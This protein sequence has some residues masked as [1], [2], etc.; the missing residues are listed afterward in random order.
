M[1]S[2]A[3]K[4]HEEAMHV[5]EGKSGLWGFLAG[6]IVAAFIAVPLSGAFAFATHPNTQQLFSGR[7]DETS[8][9]GYTAFWWIV[10]IF[11]LAL[12][13][14]VGYAV[15]NLSVKSLA[16]VGTI[17]VLFIIAA[18]VFGQLFLIV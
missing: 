12:P 3:Q 5:D 2:K 1:S 13:F 18:L 11:L 6:L 9:G 15:A 8:Q 4:Q 10:T 17:V 14:L 16:I 7:L